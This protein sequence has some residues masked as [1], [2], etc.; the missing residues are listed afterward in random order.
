MHEGAVYSVSF[1][2]DGQMLATTSVNGTVR[3]WSIESFE[4]LLARG[5]NSGQTHLKYKNPLIA[6]VLAFFNLAYFFIKI[7]AQQGF[8]KSRA[9]A[10]GCNWLKGYFANYSHN[11]KD[12]KVCDNTDSSS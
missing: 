11:R 1:S 3:L 2:P 6:R 5:C 4:R 10:L 12:L 7:L 9:F 8:Q